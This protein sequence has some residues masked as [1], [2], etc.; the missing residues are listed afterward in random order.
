MVIGGS[1]VGQI[2]HIEEIQIISSS[3]PNLA[4]MKGDKEF[5]TLAEYI[6]AIGKTK[7]TIILPE[8]KMQ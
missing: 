8:V 2:A 6:F 1:H 5:S 4:L 7:P 3:K